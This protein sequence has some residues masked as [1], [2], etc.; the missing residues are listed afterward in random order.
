MKLT[1]HRLVRHALAAALMIVSC[2]IAS[3]AQPNGG[4]AKPRT[5][6]APGDD[7]EV[8]GKV[9]HPDY[10]RLFA[11]NA[12]WRAGYEHIDV[13][14][15][16]TP[17]VLRTDP[18]EV[19]QAFAFFAEHRIKVAAVLGTVITEGCGV[20]IE[21]FGT[22]RQTEVY[23]RRMKEMGLPLDYILVDEPV[24]WGHEYS[25]KNACRYPIAD[26]AKRVAQSI[27]MAK[28]Y[29]PDAKVVLVEAPQ[30]LKG[31]PAELL[32]FLNDWRKE[33][34]ASPSVV[35]FDMQWRQDW[36]RDTPGFVRMLAAHGIPYGVIWDGSNPQARDGREWIDEAK[37]NVA[38]FHQ[39]IAAP[40]SE[41][42]IQSWSAQPE[43]DLPE[44]DPSTMAGYL[45]WFVTQAH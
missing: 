19:K 5:W 16:R 3:P 9:G 30:A 41:N 31:G 25:G 13:F 45:K 14:Q 24:T 10:G 17:W 1:K 26:V 39:L 38:A 4:P 20:G 7:L 29:Y 11:P 32:E 2:T 40:P 6:F 21:G 36:R 44:S 28:K 23:P 12:P 35:R 43:R 15:I 18:D 37:A 27:R 22:A 42:V 8:G 34:G 33:L